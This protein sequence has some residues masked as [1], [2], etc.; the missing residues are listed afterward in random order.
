MLSKQQQLKKNKLDNKILTNNLNLHLKK[1]NCMLDNKIIVIK[2][3]TTILKIKEIQPY[4]CPELED[5]IEQ[6][7]YCYRKLQEIY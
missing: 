3:G 1:C 6:K 5:I 4:I 7:I 2:A